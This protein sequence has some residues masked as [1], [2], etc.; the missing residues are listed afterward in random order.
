MLLFFFFL[1]CRQPS[2]TPDLLTVSGMQGGVKNPNQD[3]NTLPNMYRI[4]YNPGQHLRHAPATEITKRTYI[5]S[6]ASRVVFG[7]CLAILAACAAMMRCV[8]V[9]VS[10]CVPPCACVSARGVTAQRA[11]PPC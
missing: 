5:P 3:T 9:C 8:C 7:G 11:V 6:F 2:L 10:A 4:Q 1:T